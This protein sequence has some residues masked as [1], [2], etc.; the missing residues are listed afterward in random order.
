MNRR[1]R[2][3][4]NEPQLTGPLRVLWSSSVVDMDCIDVECYV[5]VVKG[6]VRSPLIDRQDGADFNN[7]WSMHIG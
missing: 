2:L 6:I 3:G 1:K 5:D 7:G 4:L